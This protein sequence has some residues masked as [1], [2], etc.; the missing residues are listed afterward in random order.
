MGSPSE[1]RNLAPV[2]VRENSGWQR[3]IKSAILN[4]L[5]ISLAWARGYTADVAQTPAR[6]PN[7][8]NSL[9]RPTAPRATGRARGQMANVPTPQAL[10]R[11]VTGIG[12]PSR[13]R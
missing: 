9:N 11:R 5:P 8:D 4:G 12:E 6:I 7:I 2:D 13:G 1:Q 3:Y 10:I